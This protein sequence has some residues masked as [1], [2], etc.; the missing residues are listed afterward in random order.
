MSLRDWEFR[1]RFWT[2]ALVFWAG[3]EAYAIDHVNIV[4]RLAAW[5]GLPPAEV[6]LAMRV[7]FGAGAALTLAAAFVRTWAA[8]Y[9]RSEVVH[10]GA[11]RS[12]RLVADGPYRYVRNPLYLGS[13]LLAVSIGLMASLVGWLVIVLGMALV[14]RRLIAREEAALVAS[15]GQ[16]YRAYLDAVPR[17]VPSMRPRV[18]SGDQPAR[19]SQAFLGEAS[20]WIFA[21]A[22]IALAAT[23]NRR[24]AFELI[25]FSVFVYAVQ[26]AIGQRRSGAAEAL[27]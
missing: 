19:W 12:E 10:D 26:W 9:L 8:A 11:V 3:F 24:V 27:R 5:M 1:F 18:P 22:A 6:P 15:Q 25:M 16:A 21:A 7:A 2:I 20:M 14:T 17:L 13:L 4:V 23:L